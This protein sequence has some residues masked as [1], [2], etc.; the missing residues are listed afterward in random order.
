[1]AVLYLKNGQNSHFSDLNDLFFII[2]SK[3]V[4]KKAQK[5]RF[6]AKNSARMTVPLRLMP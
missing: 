1:M 3:A 4:A 2:H 5:T 6:S